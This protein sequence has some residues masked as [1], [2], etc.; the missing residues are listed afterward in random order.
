M[1]TPPQNNNNNN[2][3]MI[4]YMANI[5]TVLEYSSN[6]YHSQLKKGQMNRLEQVLKRCLKISFVYRFSYMKLLE[7][8]IGCSKLP[9][10]KMTPQ[11][12]KW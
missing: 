12:L 3:L 9:R 7:L 1:T 10:K 8:S 11:F 4:I 2:K 5:H 6:A